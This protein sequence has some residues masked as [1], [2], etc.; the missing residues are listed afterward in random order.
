MTFKDQ[1]NELV[2]V[3][4]DSRPDLFL[5]A[6]KIS[7]DNHIS[8]LLDGDEGV[9]LQSCVEVSRQIEHN[10]DREQHDFSLEV[11]SAGVGSPL[12]KTR[13]YVK[14]VGRKLRIERNE[15]PTIEGTLVDAN[16]EKV[17]LEWKQREPKPVGKGKVT[18][19]K[20]ETLSYQEIVSAKVLVK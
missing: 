2:Q 20:Q 4:L 16:E 17:T 3:A 18:I 6:C 15:A 1:V 13:Q 9:N 10:L 12:K 11:A 19:T 7:T 14:N 5:I 8:I